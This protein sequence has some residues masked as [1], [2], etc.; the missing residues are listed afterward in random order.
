MQKK[1]LTT[2]NMY[3]R[4][5]GR[6]VGVVWYMDESGERKRK[7]F[8]GT[9]KQKVGKKITAYIES[10]NESIAVTDETKKKLRES[11]RSWLEVFKFPSVERT[12]YDRCECTAKNQ[13]YPKLGDRY[14]G[15]I[16]AADV[17]NL[18]TDEMNDGYAYTTVKKVYTILGEYFK[19]LY[20]QEQIPRNP[21]TN[22]EMIKRSNFMAGQGK[23]NLP[24]NE[25]V[26]VFTDDELERFKTEAFRTNQNGSRKYQQSAAYILMLNT[27][28]RTGEA[29]GLMNSDIDLDNRVMH[30]RRG[31][32]EIY[33]REGTKATSGR[34]V[35]V[36]KLK[37]MSSKRD[38][39]L[40]NTAIEMIKDLRKESY[41]GEDSPL[42]PDE[43]GNYTRPVNF[44]KRYYRILKAA[45]IEKKGLHSFR[46]T[47]A[48]RLV[49]GIKQ[50]DGTIRSLTP[51]QVADILG[52]STSQITELYYVKKD[53]KRLSGLTNEFEL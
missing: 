7:S 50:A 19:V 47:F 22:V 27:G 28:I 20:Q 21:M 13:I 51:R 46:H 52:H 8:C 4:S 31:V 48:T 26:T 15:D 17:K 25:T 14:V 33:N 10:F 30:V 32:K 6:W 1:L 23:E 3:K 53:T 41:Y 2:G 45:K 24:V 16:T 12:T 18:L 38:V 37:S 29:L 49:N 35:N 9:T 42:I 5:D 34:S 39:P 11:M 40:N 44:R 36:G 43:N